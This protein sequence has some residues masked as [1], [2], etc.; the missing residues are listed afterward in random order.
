[1]TNHGGMTDK[2]EMNG[3][4]IMYIPYTAADSPYTSWIFSSHLHMVIFCSHWLW[5]WLLM[6]AFSFWIVFSNSQ[7]ASKL[8]WPCCLSH[9]LWLKNNDFY[10]GMLSFQSN[11]E[12]SSPLR[13]GKP[14]AITAETNTICCTNMAEKVDSGDHWF[15]LTSQQK[16]PRQMNLS[17]YVL[18]GLD[19]EKSRDSTIVVEPLCNHRFRAN[20]YL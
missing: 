15:R 6:Q 12:L 18:S 2:L 1:M 7:T 13:I 16:R 19:Y 20:G 4:N 17:K 8:V 10:S 11:N 9:S 5:N 14:S 3:N